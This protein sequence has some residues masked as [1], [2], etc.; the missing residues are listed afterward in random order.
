MQTKYTQRWVYLLRYLNDGLFC[1]YYMN[2][3][4]SLPLND[5]IVETSDGVGLVLLAKDAV[6]SALDAKR[7]L[8]LATP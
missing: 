8:Q 3:K 7:S 2:T 4:S 6:K 1:D 5:Y